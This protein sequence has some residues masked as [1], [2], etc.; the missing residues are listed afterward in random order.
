MPFFSK[1]SSSELAPL[2]KVFDGKD[3]G[4]NAYE[5]VFQKP[6]PILLEQRLQADGPKKSERMR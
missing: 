1:A 5:L 2:I 3:S 6:I 4:E